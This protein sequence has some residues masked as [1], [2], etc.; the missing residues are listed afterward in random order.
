MQSSIVRTTVFLWTY[1][2]WLL[3]FLNWIILWLRKLGASFL[4]MPLKS[5]C[6]FSFFFRCFEMTSWNYFMK[7]SLK[8]CVLLI[9]S[10]KKGTYLSCS[11]PQLTSIVSYASTSSDTTISTPFFFCSTWDYYC[12][13][14]CLTSGATS[15]D[16]SSFS[17]RWRSSCFC[18]TMS[19]FFCYNRSR[20][21]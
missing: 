1:T 8:S 10:G 12:W 5:S 2:I 11:K 6:G 21:A 13:W 9:W 17:L 18:F 15:I 3:W 16:S 19:F 14:F 20:S 7:S 4:W